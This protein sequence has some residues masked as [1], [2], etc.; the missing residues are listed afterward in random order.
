MS[1]LLALDFVSTISAERSGSVDTLADVE[2][3][4][5]WGRAHAAEL[6]LDAE[7]PQIPAAARNHCRAGAA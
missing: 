7:T 6:G 5:A 2:G 3:M 4:T 1:S